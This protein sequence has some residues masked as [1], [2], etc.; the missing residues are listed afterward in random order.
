GSR[1]RLVSITLASIVVAGTVGA[2]SWEGFHLLQS[3]DVPFAGG[4]IGILFDFLFLSLFVMLFFSTA[5]I[6]YG[7]LFSSPETACL[8]ATPAR[9]DHIYAYKFQT[10]IAFS[11]WAFLL[12]GAPIL[13][14][15]GVVYPRS[16]HFFAALPVLL[17]GFILLP[18]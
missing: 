10:A 9:A 14:A 18:G 12:L 2:A 5:I 1:V 15:Y 11:S 16:W 6:V 13:I 17:L 8:L 7:S 3:R 4:I